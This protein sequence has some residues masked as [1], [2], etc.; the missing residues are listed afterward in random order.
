[1]KLVI[2]AVSVFS[3]VAF[4]SGKTKNSK[5][6]HRQHEAHVHGAGSLAIAFD[7][8]RGRIEFKGAAEGVLGFEH[9]P[10][11]KK[12]QLVVDK[13]QAQFEREIG[14][15]VQF[16]KALNCQFAKEQIGQVPE[17]GEESSGE[18]SDWAAT[19]NVTC[20]KSPAGTKVTVDFSQFKLIKDIDITLLVGS[21]QKTAEFKK[22]PVTIEIK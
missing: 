16:D 17:E 3:M 15:M 18:H 11:N 13:A 8:A 9:K 10:K 7:D 1:M 4:A 6:E 5:T 21:V 14:Q 20:A 22:K 19:Y 12:D 2:L